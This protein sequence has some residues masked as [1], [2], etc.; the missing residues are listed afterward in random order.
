VMRKCLSLVQIVAFDHRKAWI[1]FIALIIYQLLHLCCVYL[2]C[3]CNLFDSDCL[4]FL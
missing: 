1:V 4:T 3:T 2:Q